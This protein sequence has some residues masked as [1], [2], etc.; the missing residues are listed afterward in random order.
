MPVPLLL[1]AVGAS[2]LLEAGRRVNSAW[3]DYRLGRAYL[4]DVVDLREEVGIQEADEL[5]D[6]LDHTA[7]DVLSVACNEDAYSVAGPDA[8]N[9]IDA[10][11]DYMGNT[12]GIISTAETEEQRLQRLCWSVDDANDCALQDPIPPAIGEEVRL[13]V[14]DDDDTATVSS[15][16][17]SAD[18]LS[19]DE[20]ASEASP[21]DRGTQASRENRRTVYTVHGCSSSGVSMAGPPSGG[22]IA[23]GEVSAPPRWRGPR[24]T[25]SRIVS[26]LVTKVKVKF[27]AV[28]MD[29]ANLLA[30]R[31]ELGDL[32]K[33]ADAS[34]VRNCDKAHI[35]DSALMIVFVPT[36]QEKLNAQLLDNWVVR[37]RQK[38]YFDTRMGGAAI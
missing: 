32:L 20:T 13:P 19:G 4:D 27:G 17:S 7:D 15:S 21:V 2:G 34:D 8:S 18:G 28:K 11:L 24:R 35:L 36:K 29:K 5:E 14:G 25:K 16:L 37:R 30:V 3:R 23:T 31:R 12:I 9:P 38:S 6:T 33:E 10:I 1:V 22:A 26:E